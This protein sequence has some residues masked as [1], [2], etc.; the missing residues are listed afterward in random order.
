LAIDRQGTDGDTSQEHGRPVV[1]V[2]FENGVVVFLTREEAA[3]GSSDNPVNVV[4]DGLKYLRES[5]PGS[6][7]ARYRLHRGVRCRGGDGRAATLSL[8]AAL[9]R[10]R[11]TRNLLGSGRTLTEVG[12]LGLLGRS[13]LDR[14]TERGTKETKEATASQKAFDLINPPALT[15]RT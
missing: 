12:S 6:D 1:L 2:D 11:R 13:P 9:R 10:R 15:L 5:G 14:V 8:A 3:V 7:D 4:T